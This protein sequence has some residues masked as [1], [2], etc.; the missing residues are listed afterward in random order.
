MK[1]TR[2]WYWLGLGP[3][4]GRL[5]LLLTTTGRKSGLPRV[6]PL[7]YEEIDGVIYVAPARGRKADWFR[8]ILS[9]PRVEVRVKSERF[10]GVAEPITDSARIADFLE[11]R[12]QRHP[13][14][15]GA[16]LWFAGL[17]AQPDRDQLERYATKIALVA[18]RPH[19]K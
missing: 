6:T 11:W 18:I 19:E 10:Q 14:M 4:V 15:I 16:M 8:N 13:R 3:I 17:P 9:D 5:I 1:F 7:Q 2:V 12:L